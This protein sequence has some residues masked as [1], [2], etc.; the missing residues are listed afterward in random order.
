M[1]RSKRGAA[2]WLVSGFALL[3]F[4]S[5]CGGSSS[6]SGTQSA[7][8]RSTFAAIHRTVTPTRRAEMT[9]FTG[10]AGLAFG[11]F[12]RYVYPLKGETLKTRA[13]RQRAYAKARAAAS[14]A[15]RQ[16][17]LAKENGVQST[18]LRK[19]FG[20]LAALEPMLGSVARGLGRGHFDAAGVSSTNAAI[21]YIE[22][23]GSIGGVK[24]VERA[25]ATIHG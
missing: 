19:L 15:A 4:L 25:P 21:A 24:I 1:S 12:H 23:S 7:A 5:A 2:A 18:A 8:K 20:P 10:H 13:Q 3:A 22:H 6:L 17:V 9:T 14:A 16:V 11:I